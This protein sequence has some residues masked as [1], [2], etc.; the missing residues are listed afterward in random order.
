MISQKTL[1]LLNKNKI[2]IICVII[3]LFVAC[4]NKQKEITEFFLNILVG[5]KNY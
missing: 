1:E 5:E 3:L 4:F 2:I